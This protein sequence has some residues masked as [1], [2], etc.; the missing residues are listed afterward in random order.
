MKLLCP[1]Y[2]LQQLYTPDSPAAIGRYPYPPG[3]LLLRVKYLNQRYGQVPPVRISLTEQDSGSNMK[4]FNDNSLFSSESDIL[5][6]YLNEISQ[7]ISRDHEWQLSWDQGG[8]GTVSGIAVLNEEFLYVFHRAGR[9]WEG[10]TFSS[11]FKITNS[12]R[13]EE[14]TIL[15]C[16]VYDGVC[17]KS[18]GSDMFLMPHGISV[19]PDKNLLVT[20]TGR[21]QVFMLDKEGQIMLELGE[22]KTPGNDA[23]HFCQPADAEIDPVSELLFVADGYCNQRVAVFDQNGK[24]QTSIE[25]CNRRPFKVV[26]DLAIDPQRRILFVADRENT[27]VCMYSL[28]ENSFGKFID[29]FSLS[30]TSVYSLDYNPG[31]LYAVGINRLLDKASGFIFSIE[32]DL[33]STEESSFTDF[34]MEMPHDVSVLENEVLFVSDLNSPLKVLKFNL[35]VGFF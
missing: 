2:K 1:G 19:T 7:K 16:H 28:H 8:I 22:D 15:K 32:S 34:L 9:N 26:H 10:N 31:F 17:V 24:F 23:S 20:D 6:Q 30:E 18:F 5:W 25:D 35:D 11:D 12:T 27:E 14:D 29:A 21:H 4:M 3:G 13:L 33:E